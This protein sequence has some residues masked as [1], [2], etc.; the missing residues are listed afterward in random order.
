MKTFTH[1]D[2]SKLLPYM[3]SM[4]IKK[5]DAVAEKYAAG[6]DYID[7]ELEDIVLYHHAYRDHF[8][9]QT[10]FDIAPICDKVFDMIEEKSDRQAAWRILS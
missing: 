1:E 6:D 10:A 8:Q 3:T 7:E 4:A 2:I 9:E 5:L